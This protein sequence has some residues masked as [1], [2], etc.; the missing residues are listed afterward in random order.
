METGLPVLT[1]SHD[2]NIQNNHSKQFP[3]MKK[4]WFKRRGKL[5][6]KDIPREKENIQRA[7]T[8]SENNRIAMEFSFCAGTLTENLTNLRAKLALTSTK[9]KIADLTGIIK[10]AEFIQSNGPIIA[11]T[12]AAKIFY[13][14]KAIY[15]ENSA[16]KKRIK[17]SEFFQKIAHFLNL[18]QVYIFG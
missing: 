15:L 6:I 18:K 8:F 14:E 16:I 7:Q 11:T 9:T 17:S 4:E 10:T 3:L 2:R 13:E 12:D 1:I 5:A